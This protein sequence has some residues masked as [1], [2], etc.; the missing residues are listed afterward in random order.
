MKRLC[1]FLSVVAGLSV[2]AGLSG[3][4]TLIGGSH[5]ATTSYAYLYLKVA[6]VGGSVAAN[7]SGTL[8][9]ANCP[10]GVC[11]L[12]FP[13]GTAVTLTPTAYGGSSFVGWRTIYGKA[14][15]RC[16]GPHIACNATVSGV[17]GIKAAFTPVELSV[18]STAGGWVELVTP[19]TSCGNGCRRYPYGTQAVIRAHGED[20][21][22]FAGWGGICAGIGSGCQ[23]TLYDNQSIGASFACHVNPCS[24]HDPVTGDVSITVNVHGPG[25]AVFRGTQCRDHCVRSAPKLALVSIEAQPSPGASF[26]GWRTSAVNCAGFGSRCSFPAFGNQRGV[27]PTVDVYFR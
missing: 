5:A 11:V 17:M 6:G 9:D 24:T 14:D 19:G 26:G 16:G 20:G 8:I 2:I 25:S 27:G 21:Y 1:I 23:F 15:L 22:S 3:S 7:P 4:A 18:G 12:A 13:E 10:G